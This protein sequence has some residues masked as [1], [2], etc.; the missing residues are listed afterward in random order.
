MRS[1]CVRCDD[2]ERLY[3]DQQKCV[4]WIVIRRKSDVLA[5][6]AAAQAMAPSIPAPRL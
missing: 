1:E 5:R 2:C 6:Q 3:M 4:H